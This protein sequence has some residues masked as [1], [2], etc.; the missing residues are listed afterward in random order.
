MKF[1]VK[2]NATTA[3][4]GPGFDCVGLALDLK[5]EILVSDEGTERLTIRAGEGVP[6]DENNLI[7][8]AMDEVFKAVGS[9][10]ESLTI[11]QTDRIP[12]ASG[13][14]SSAACIALGVSAA[15]ALSGGKLTE[16]E[17][18]DVATRLDGHPDNV[19]PCLVGGAAAAVMNKDGGVEQYVRF[20]V[21]ERLFAVALTP[22]F[23]LSTAA[24]RKAL[25]GS[26][27]RAD[28]V[29]S[30]S[31]AVVCFAA[32]AT[33]EYDKLACLDDKLHQPYRSPLI[34]GY[35]EAVAAL[36]GGGA[37][38]AFL[39]GAGPTVL[40]IFEEKNGL[41]RGNVEVNAPRGWVKRVLDFDDAGVVIKGV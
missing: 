13:L 33:G 41:N 35:G 18:I 17:L 37:T 15:N 7:Y 31:R 29:Y 22:D 24:S 27:P 4:V 25:P 5:N 36:R 20:G 28:V 38:C 30:L 16:R 21:D 32:L 40:G 2:A 1:I 26:Y 9:R 34:P 3:N 19:L 8:R 14:G 6:T 12:M 23:P 10:P 11:E 39:S